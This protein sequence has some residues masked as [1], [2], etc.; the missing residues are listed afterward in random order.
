MSLVCDWKHMQVGQFE[1]WTVQFA[2]VQDVAAEV[3]LDHGEWN[4]TIYCGPNE[5]PGGTATSAEEA[6]HAVLDK[7]ERIPH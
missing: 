1:G 5:W 2:A 4:W 6:M 7:I 3:W